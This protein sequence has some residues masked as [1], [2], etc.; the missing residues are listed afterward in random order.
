[1]EIFINGNLTPGVN[2]QLDKKGYIQ[3]HFL[4]DKQVRKLKLNFGMNK[5]TYKLEGFT[6]DAEI[7]LYADNDRLVVSDVD[8]TVTKNDLG[9]HLHNFLSKDYLHEGYADLA[10]KIDK[11]GYKMVW[12][13]MRALPLYDY[14]KNYLRETCKIDG[15]ILM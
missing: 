4:A 12:L 15:P 13:T 5:V 14:S 7:Y 10:Q 3:P 9:G 11:N 8:G 6:I 2:F 1:V